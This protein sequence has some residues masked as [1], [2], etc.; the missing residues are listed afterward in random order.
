MDTPTVPVAPDVAIVAAYER[1]AAELR[2]AARWRYAQ[3]HFA[4]ADS[5]TAGGLRLQG[6]ARQLTREVDRC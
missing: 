3:R 5:L 4:Q 2:E 1:L 6:R